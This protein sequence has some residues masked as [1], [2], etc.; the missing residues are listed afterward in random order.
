LLFAATGL[1][2]ASL[3]PLGAAM[4]CDSE[5]RPYALDPL[6]MLLPALIFGMPLALSILSARSPLAVIGC[7]LIGGP[8]AGAATGATASAYSALALWQVVSIQTSS[9]AGMAY[10]AAFGIALAWPGFVAVRFRGRPA[11][12]DFDRVLVSLG[13]WLIAVYAAITIPFRALGLEA[14]TWVG[15]ANGVTAL[16]LGMARRHARKL[17]FL[18]VR[19][20]A[21]EDWVVREW[22]RTKQVEGLLPLFG[23]S[24]LACD[25]V[26]VH[27]VRLPGSPYRTDCIE[28]P[29]LL[30]PGADQAG[31]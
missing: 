2:V 16:A 6:Q 3:A 22:D 15:V 21:V 24:R 8:L 20:G 27:R 25:A 18:R 11:H 29:V 23:G 31:S 26:L 7:A 4:L 17:W 30:A 28:T 9:V 19:A 13:I 12:D 14:V 1:V 5:G 10:G